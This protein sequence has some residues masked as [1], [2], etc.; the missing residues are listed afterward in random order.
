[1]TTVRLDEAKRREIMLTAARRIVAERGF[2]AVTHG[3][4][5]KR[6]VVPTSLALVRRY[7][8]TKD[9]LWRATIGSDPVMLEAAREAGWVE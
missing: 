7:F 8:S 6:C 9:E 1:M 5:A 3:T 2:W 4:V